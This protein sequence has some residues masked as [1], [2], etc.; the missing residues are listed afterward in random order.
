MMTF[1]WDR[2]FPRVRDRPPTLSRQARDIS[3]RKPAWPLT[4]RGMAALSFALRPLR[5]D[6]APHQ[7]AERAGRGIGMG[8]LVPAHGERRRVWRE[9]RHKGAEAETRAFCGEQRGR[10]HG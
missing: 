6:D 5:G 9:R 8:T 3:V 1:G 10:E 7:R 2:G 4:R